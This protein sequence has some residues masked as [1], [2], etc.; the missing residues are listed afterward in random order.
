MGIIAAPGCHIR[1]DPTPKVIT[2]P[3]TQRLKL[4]QWQE[5]DL[6]PFAALNAD[7]KVMKY[8][9]APLTREQSDSLAGRFKAAIEANDGWGFWVAEL[10]TTKE[11]VGTVGLAC[12]PDRFAFS[13]CTEIGW[14][15]G[16]AFWHQGLAQEA[17]AAALEFAFDRLELDKVVSFTSV[18]NGPSENLMQRLGMIRQGLFLHPALPADDYLAEHVWYSISRNGFGG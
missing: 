3:E 10:K 13:P 11:F 1:Y 17:A 7:P 5:G 4:R 2:M 15:L 14:R 18:H 8:F 9:P 6:L 16:R 12:Q